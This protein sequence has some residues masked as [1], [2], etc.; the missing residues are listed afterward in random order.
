MSDHSWDSSDEQI[1]V[2]QCPMTD[3]YLQP[4][5]S[6]SADVIAPVQERKKIEDD[7]MQARHKQENFSMQI[8]GNAILYKLSLIKLHKAYNIHYCMVTPKRRPCRLQ[9]ADCAGHAA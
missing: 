9:T 4:C 7:N 5:I 3:C 6:N 1:L 8:C 2:S